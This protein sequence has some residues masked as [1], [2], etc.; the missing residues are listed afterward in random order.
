MEEIHDQLPPGSPET[1][2]F[3]AHRNCRWAT[4]GGRSGKN[5]IA[6]ELTHPAKIAMDRRKTCVSRYGEP[7]ENDAPHREGLGCGPSRQR[8][9]TADRRKRWYEWKDSSFF[10]RHLISCVCWVGPCCRSDLWLLRSPRNLQYFC[11]GMVEREEDLLLHGKRNNNTTSELS[12]F[13][14]TM[15]VFLGLSLPISAS[16]CIFLSLSADL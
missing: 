3:A 13:H 1:G 16:I 9:M 7:M 6:P 12:K 4:N 11:S 8:E 2:A 5:A 10:F 15:M 14:R